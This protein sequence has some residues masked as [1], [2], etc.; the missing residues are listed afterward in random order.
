MVTVSPLLCLQ[1]HGLAVLLALSTMCTSLVIMYSNM[2]TM[3]VQS[4]QPPSAATVRSEGKTSA[5]EDPPIPILEGYISV[6]DH[7]VGWEIELSSAGGLPGG[8]L[9]T[10]L[11]VINGPHWHF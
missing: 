1:R 4:S 6:L 8:I 10:A 5:K 3:K 2:R 11:V 9:C 7:K